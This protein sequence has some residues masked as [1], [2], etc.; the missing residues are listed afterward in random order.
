MLLQERIKKGLRASETGS[1]KAFHPLC[2]VS[3]AVLRGKFENAERAGYA[4]A[5][6]ACP[7]DSLAIIHQQ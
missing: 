7:D 6:T 1:P 5:L 2:K 4:Q 3:Q